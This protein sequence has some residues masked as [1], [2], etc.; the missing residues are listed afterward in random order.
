MITSSH[1][2]NSWCNCNP[3][4][5]FYTYTTNTSDNTD[6]T[7]TDSGGNQITYTWPTIYPSF[8][9]FGTTSTNPTNLSMCG[10]VFTEQ[11]GVLI[12]NNCTHPLHQHR[13]NHWPKSGCAL[14]YKALGLDINER[15]TK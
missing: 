9:P 14:C 8:W 11:N 15:R 6:D 2:H 1:I 4:K 7:T 5:I 13:I 10:K 12:C 3:I